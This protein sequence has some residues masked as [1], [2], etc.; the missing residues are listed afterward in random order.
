M[1]FLFDTSAV[2]RIRD[3]K[4]P[5]DAWYPACVTDLVR[6]FLCWGPPA[7]RPDTMSVYTGHNIVYILC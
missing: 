3:R 5:A 6:D 7:E 1:A 4:A 2:N